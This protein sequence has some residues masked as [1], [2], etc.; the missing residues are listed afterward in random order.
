M[1]LFA[2][3][4][5]FVHLAN[6]RWEWS[7]TIKTLKR[8]F[9]KQHRFFFENS[10]VPAFIFPILTYFHCDWSNEAGRL[11]SKCN[12][13]RMKHSGDFRMKRPPALTSSSSP[14]NAC[15]QK[16]LTKTVWCVWLDPSYRSTGP[17][18]HNKQI[19]LWVI[20]NKKAYDSLSID[21][22]QQ[23]EKGQLLSVIFDSLSDGWPLYSHLHVSRRVCCSSPYSGGV[24]HGAD[25]V[26]SGV[27]AVRS[28]AQSG[29]VHR[30]GR[31]AEGGRD[32]VP[33]PAQWGS[34]RQWLEEGES[35]SSVSHL[36][37]GESVNI[38]DHSE[39]LV[40]ISKYTLQ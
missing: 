3:L 6:K 36:W 20:A 39:K 31:S 12:L 17:I 5:C 21:V 23:K 33:P 34:D 28:R 29:C 22:H 26:S 13:H 37:P 10:L 35:V 40:N 16:L 24:H 8:K 27:W 7:S 1:V 9:E 38:Q 18:S 4:L 25:S 2:G 30:R 19:K 14:T 15:A 32:A 11:S